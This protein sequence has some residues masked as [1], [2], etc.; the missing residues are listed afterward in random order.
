MAAAAP[1]AGGSRPLP[2]VAGVLALAVALGAGVLASTGLP[3]SESLVTSYA[4]ASATG[5]TLGLLAGGCLLTAG[6]LAVWFGRSSPVG[7]LL[8]ASGVLWFAPDWAGWEGGPGVVRGLATLVTPLLP[9][10][11]LGLLATLSGARRRGPVAA[12]AVVGALSVGFA[13]VDDPFLDPVC[14]PTCSDNT[15]LISSQPALADLLGVALSLASIGV[16]GLAGFGAGRG[17]LAASSVARR[18]NGALLGALVAVAAVEVAYGLAALLGTETADDPLFVRIHVARAVAWSLLALAAAWTTHRHLARRR[19]L[20]GLAAELE[21]TGGPL[22][23]ASTLRSVTGDLDLDVR[24]PVGHD[25][26]QVGADGRT[27]PTQ[28]G[29]GRTA[30]PLRRGERTVAVLVHDPV[31]LPVDALDAVLGPAARLALDNERLSAERL[32]RAY[33]VQE[34]QR[35]IV[36][37]GDEARR[38]LE[39]DLHDGA[40]QSLL[41]LSY[42]LRLT[43]TTA[44][45]AG[46]W[47]AVAEL[48]RGLSLAQGALDDL[49]RLAHGIHPAVLSQSGL[50]V[51][52]RALAEETLVPLELEKVP[53][54][55]FD[56]SIELAAWVVVRDAA[57]RAGRDPSA[58]LV[59][60]AGR[61]GDRLV[62]EV[63]GAGDRLPT[64]TADRVGALGGHLLETATGLRVELPCAS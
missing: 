56:A 35:R 39:R 2:D 57:D 55:R 28:P 21:T 18:W 44:E 24:Y 7:V 64:V 59:V 23:L 4:M 14:W 48:D 63:D 13:V 42:L 49:R 29:P 47:R 9:V 54:E 3:S 36:R 12:A 20:A 8:V 30:T 1:V 32:A 26:R 50:A 6:A 19:S 16:A 58:A 43:R 22:P 52:L 10:A 38:R 46:E 40:Q 51:A 5:R 27:A 31:V 62:V 33:D 41:A 61:D 60:R 15:L 11:L 17:L 37:T 45:R 53:D 34:S 25:E